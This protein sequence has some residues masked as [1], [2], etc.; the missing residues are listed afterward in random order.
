MRGLVSVK[1]VVDYNVKVRAQ[2]P[3][4]SKVE[5]AGDK[6]NVTRSRPA[7]YLCERL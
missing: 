3:F 2:G 6:L 5:V 4:A 1:R 7:L